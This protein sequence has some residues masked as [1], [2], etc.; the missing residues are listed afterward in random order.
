MRGPPSGELT[1]LCRSPAAVIGHQAAVSSPTSISH[2]SLP[3]LTVAVSSSTLVIL[4][5]YSSP[6]SVNDTFCPTV[7]SG[8]ALTAFF[9][10]AGFSSGG[11]SSA[12]AGSDDAPSSSAGKYPAARG[13]SLP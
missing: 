2:S 7:N 9:L 3:T 4:P 6:S 12:G 8:A 10:A 13:L 5:V 1:P 11:G